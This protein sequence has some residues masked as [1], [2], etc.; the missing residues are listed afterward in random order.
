[1]KKTPR[2]ALI[3]ITV[4]LLTFGFACRASSDITEGII[5]NGDDAIDSAEQL[6][7]GILPV[8]GEDATAVDPQSQSW[9]VLFYLDADD[10]V[11][12]EDMFYD[13]NEIEMVGSTDRVTMLAQM[14]RYEGAYDGDGDWSS[15]RRYYLTQDADLETVNSQMIED[16]GEVDMGSAQTLVDFATW[17]IQNYPA[18]RVVLILSDHGSGWPGGWSDTKPSRSEGNW[19]Y[20]IDIQN[21][22]SQIITNT[23]ISQFEMIGMDAC[24]MSMLEV[25]NGLAPYAHYAVASQETE[26]AM[27][28]A[29]TSFLSKLVANPEMSGADLSRAVVDGYITEDQRIVND[30][31]RRKLLLS[32]GVSDEVSAEQIAQEFQTNI[33]ITAVDLTALPGLNS[34]LDAFVTSLKNVDQ[35]RVAEARSYAQ[36]FYNVFNDRYPSPYIDLVN[37]ADFTV[38]IIGDPAVSQNAQVMKDALSQVVIAEKHGEQRPGA[39]GISIYFPVSDLYWDENTGISYYTLASQNFTQYTLWDDFLAF[40]Y[41]GQDF[42]L[43]NPAPEDQLPAPGA[44][45]V[46]ISPLTLSSNVIGTDEIVNIQ[47]DITGDRVAYIYLVGL[48][49]NNTSD[50]YLAFYIDYLQMSEIGDEVNGVVFPVYDRKDGVIHV[51]TDW[52]LAADGV[53]DANACVFALVNPDKFTTQPEKRLYYVEGWYVYADTGE[54]VEAAAYFNNKGNNQLNTIIANPVSDGSGVTTPSEIIPRSGDQ[55]ITV[56]TVLTFNETGQFTGEYEEGNVLTFGDAPL[57]FGTFG[58]P[59]PGNYLVGIMVMDMDGNKTWQFAPVAITSDENPVTPQDF[60]QEGIQQS[61]FDD[62]Q[63]TPSTLHPQ[64]GNASNTSGEGWQSPQAKTIRSPLIPIIGALI[65]VLLTLIF[66]V[67]GKKARPGTVQAYPVTPP[68]HVQPPSGNVSKP[69]ALP[70]SPPPLQA[71]PP[72]VPR[73]SKSS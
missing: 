48:I 61:E 6:A 69:P 11:L 14:D 1:M 65:G 23:G 24:L 51:S 42:G 49:K 12:E 15:T 72:P 27:G 8:V 47:T 43:G 63:S 13:L 62:S 55:F 73:K 31:A 56:N 19:L 16:L 35:A 10:P 17:G 38:Q 70:A 57:N 37:F 59:D 2:T 33:T 54:R 7:G 58:T 67:G 5:G 22:L 60:P 40:H 53:C 30:D 34:S 3:F 25:Y 32:Y 71:T 20:L 21:A 4:F 45:Q 26:P 28:W 29:Y 68:P 52:N 36:P 41:S 44:A 50:R 66:G 46:T 18:D 39:T 9:L 64:G